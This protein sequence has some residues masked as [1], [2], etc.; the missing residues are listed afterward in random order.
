MPPTV[1][2]TNR[3][4]PEDLADLDGL[5]RIIHGP[6]DGSLMP[7]AKVMELFPEVDAIITNADMMVDEA[8]LDAASMLKIVAVV[9]I[10]TDNLDIPALTRRGVW[11]TNAPDAFT[12]TTGD[13]AM[14]LLL[15]VARRIVECDRY[16]RTGD[17]ARD[18]FQPERWLGLETLLGGQ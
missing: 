9:A 10:G 15:A 11:A 14:A 6:P 2:L 12:E 8:M 13:S 3:T 1:L 16:V 17:W 5:A 7:R 4:P 18:R